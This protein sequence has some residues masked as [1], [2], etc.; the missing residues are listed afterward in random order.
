MTDSNAP[1]VTVGERYVLVERLAVDD[2]REVW[3]GHDDLASRQVVVKLYD[4]TS[5]ADPQW[6]R[7]FHHGAQRLTALSDPGIAS[8]L[9]H[10]AD[11][12]PVW[13]VLANVPG[14]LL[15]T[16]SAA[17][18]LSVDHALR[19][20]GQTALALKTAHDAGV[21]HGGLSARHV[22]V[23]D[24][25]SAALIGFDLAGRHLP[26]DDIAAFR[27]L[28]HEVLPAPAGGD[29][30]SESARFLNWL[31]GGKQPAPADPG[32][33]GRTALALA[34]TA[35]GGQTTPLMPITADTDESEPAKRRPWYDDAERKRVRNGLITLGTV[36]VIAGGALLWLVDR[37]G[38]P[39]H[40]TVP[41]VI[42]LS[43]GDA[44][45]QL[46]QD[47]L[48]VTENVT[49]PKGVVTAQSPP[50]GTQVKVGTLVTLTVRPAAG[51]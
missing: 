39:N 12:P 34:A 26:A 7:R 28:A 14:R 50:G 16:M 33:I 1:L 35:R 21:I 37:G 38:G 22:V 13:L 31:D 41:T 15:D 48:R 17:G 42:G 29:T 5:A 18:G 27:A 32:D 43:L 47:V 23:R 46:T 4:G 3:H 2:E 40:V 36:V 20:L 19:V 49:D 25:G 9:D 6:R 44:Q 45:N 10:D 30:E 11:E 24:D 8:V 51:S